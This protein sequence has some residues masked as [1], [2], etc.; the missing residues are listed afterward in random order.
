MNVCFLVGTFGS[1]KAFTPI[2]LFALLAYAF[3]CINYEVKKK[4]VLPFSLAGTLLLFIYFK[5]YSFIPEEVHLAWVYSSI[6]LSYI[7]FRVIHLQVDSSAGA[8]RE[9]VSIL[10]FFNYVFSAFSFV[11]GPI[12]RFSEY[13]ENQK[14]AL[15]FRTDEKGVLENV[16]RIANGYIK[17]YFISIF[18]NKGFGWLQAELP[19]ESL[20]THSL[21]VLF[22]TGFL[23]YNFSGYMDIV[24]GWA[25]LFGIKLPENFNRPF[26]SKNFLDFWSR[27]HI[28]L[29]DWFK[30]Y[31]FNPIVTQ[32]AR[33]SNSK[34]W[35]PY[36][37]VSAF[38]VTFLIMGLWHGTTYVFFIYGLLL[39][40]GVSLNKLY[41]VKMKV[42][43]GKKKFALLRK[44]V[45]YTNLC[46][47][48]TISYFSH[49]LI[50]LWK[51]TGSILGFAQQVG[52]VRYVLMFIITTVLIFLFRFI[53]QYIELLFV[54]ISR[55]W[56]KYVQTHSWR[57]T[58]LVPTSFR[59][60]FVS[61]ILKVR[62]ENPGFVYEVF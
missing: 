37:G 38:F 45:F 23:Y 28:T 46:Q 61:L 13:E 7:L 52:F 41:E 2:L 31:V 51:N 62:M 18:F 53:Y 35:L 32:L 43:L 56:E 1:L 29:S 24:I 11:S 8:L 3:V 19:P 44:H 9:R 54:H 21:S 42:W 10:N 30:Y 5:R 14:K 49:A 22:Y 55:E 34:T 16:S 6:G 27:W 60:L 4:W 26:E 33:L 36:F 20:Y 50:C 57:L 39:G 17:V 59:C 40:F 48:M 12:Q 15:L 58:Y 25:G 47:A